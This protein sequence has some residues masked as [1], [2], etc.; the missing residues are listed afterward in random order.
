MAEL[1][2]LFHS[3]CATDAMKQIF[4]SAHYICRQRRASRSTLELKVSMREAIR[5]GKFLW[6]CGQLPG[7]RYMK[8]LTCLTLAQ[9]EYEEI[10]KACEN[11]LEHRMSCW[12]RV[13]FVERLYESASESP[14]MHLRR[15][16]A[17]DAKQATLLR[18]AL[19]GTLSIDWGA[20]ASPAQSWRNRRCRAASDFAQYTFPAARAQR[21][22]GILKGGNL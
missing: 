10:E 4:L 20:T 22:T 7:R 19:R 11:R 14:E 6:I 21:E 9:V 1:L 3:V 15:K 8:L 16:S 18:L 13:S 5:F 12:P 17:M 2:K